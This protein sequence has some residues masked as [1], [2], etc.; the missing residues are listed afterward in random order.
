MRYL[1]DGDQM[2]NADTHTIRQIGIP[3]LVLMERAALKIVESIE[4][5]DVSLPT[6]SMLN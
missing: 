6:S 2:K 1:P 4:Q 3:S 5:A